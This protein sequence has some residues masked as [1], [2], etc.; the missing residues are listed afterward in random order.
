MRNK[1]VVGL[2]FIIAFNIQ[3]AN[4]AFIGTPELIILLIVGVFTLAFFIGIPLLIYT[5]VKH[6]G[7][8]P[9]S[10]KINITQPIP[11]KET[12][13]TTDTEFRKTDQQSAKIAL[14]LQYEIRYVSADEIIRCEANDNYTNFHLIDSEK[15]LISKPLKEYSD[16]LKPQGFVRA[17]QSHLVNPKFVKSSLKEDGG[18]LLM[19][20]GDKIPVS[21]PNREMVKAVLGK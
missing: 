10:V 9:N 12:F 18:M 8:N 15:I 19:N 2:I 6:R 11:Y 20:N 21:K 17:H 13:S 16:L 14:P 7:I 4:A 5:L 3:I 1:I